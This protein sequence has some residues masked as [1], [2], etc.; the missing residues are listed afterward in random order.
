MTADPAQTSA[1]N[2]LGLQD[3]EIERF[4]AG[5]WI[6][7]YF[8]TTSSPGIAVTVKRDSLVRL[9]IVEINDPGGGIATLL[10]LKERA[11]AVARA[12]GHDHFEVFGAAMINTRFKSLLLRKGFSERTE[13][14][15][16]ELGG[17]SMTIVARVEH[18]DEC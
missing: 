17:G 2:A 9:G 4:L 1:L 15:P 6:V 12:F 14:C 3:D 18:V 7:F 13:L 5:E 8:P 10:R 11:R 16:E